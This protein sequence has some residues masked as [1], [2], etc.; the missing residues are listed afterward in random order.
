MSQDP[1]ALIEQSPMT[2][3]QIVAVAMCVFLNALDGFDVL[4][5][6]FASPGIAEEWG[7]DRAALGV[8]LAM[9]LVGMAVGAFVIGNIADV[10]GRRPVIL[11]ALVIMSGGMFAASTAET[12]NTLLIFR[13]ITGFG[14]GGMLAA[15]NAMAAEYANLK[16]RSL[17][18]TVMA[19]GFPVGIILGGTVASLLLIQFDWRSIFIFG[20]IVTGLVIPITMM[21]L[22]ESIDFLVQRRPKGALKKINATLARMK[23]AA[24]EA[25]PERKEKPKVGLRH[26]FT[27]AMA[28][29]TILLTAA[30]FAHIMTYY[31]ILKWIPKIVVDMGFAAPLAGGVLV[32]AN[33]GG[34][35]GAVLL[36][37]L[38]Q[39]WSVRSLVVGTMLIGAVAVV[40]F[41]RGQVDLVEL[42]IVAACVGFFTNAGVVGLYAMFA[43]GFPTEMRASGTGF[44]IGIGRGG[45][46]L[47]P[48]IAGFLFNS[49]ASLQV[50]AI[51]MAAGSVIGAFALLRLRL[52]KSG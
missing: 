8:V 6:S 49:G 36:G 20:G 1:K 52:K 43:Q 33:V 34:A 32:W 3:M 17:A 5:I 9:E 29:T 35:T 21:L 19:A 46:A 15:T 51:V 47:G 24:I 48:I 12:I 7:I 2:P 44:A 26:L 39:R 11:A 10:V 30:Y 25:L 14:I 38:T 40:V 28:Q 4:S 27:P 16:H 23:H 13:F 31:F 50:V 37:L 45:A 18:V 22:P 41:G 42:S